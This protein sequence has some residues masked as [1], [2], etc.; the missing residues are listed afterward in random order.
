[1]PLALQVSLEPE[2]QSGVTHVQPKKPDLEVAPVA[3]EKLE[4]DPLSMLIILS[5][6]VLPAVLGIWAFFVGLLRS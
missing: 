4:P 5:P 2:I 3:V 1:M 6:V